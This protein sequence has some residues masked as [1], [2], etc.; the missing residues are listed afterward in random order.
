MLALV[1]P[2]AGGKSELSL[3][4]AERFDA[5]I[6]SVDSMQVYRGMDVGTAKPT[7]EERQQVP[8]HM[9]DLVE[10]EEEYS[11]AAFQRRGRDVIEAVHARGRNVLVVGGSGLHFRALLDPLEFPGHDPVVRQA[12]ETLEPDAARAELLA[13]DPG[14]GD[15]VDLENPRRVAR[16]LEVVRIGGGTPSERAG[17]PAAVA[18]REYRALVPFTGVVIDPGDGL[19]TRARRRIDKMLK[20]GLLAEVERLA[21]RLGRTA[22]Q[23]VGYKELLP[24]VEG[25]LPLSAGAADVLTATLALAR[26][27]RTFFGRDPRLLPIPWVSVVEQRLAAVEEAFGG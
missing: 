20:R 14:A 17:S 8:H 18:V 16:A 13:A 15:H 6:L 7:W 10:P 22:S 5:E 26:R 23:A 4:L 12:V 1:G 3:R 11:V 9:L 24:V 19:S 27:Q 2:T 25:R 21:P